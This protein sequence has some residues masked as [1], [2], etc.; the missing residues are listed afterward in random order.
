[1]LWIAL[2][3]LHTGHDISV[4]SRVIH[5]ERARCGSCVEDEA[6]QR[7]YR[8]PLVEFAVF[9]LGPPAIVALAYIAGVWFIRRRRI[10]N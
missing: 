1:M 10:S 2:F 8:G 6:V 7:L 3:L 9:G 4:L 5:D